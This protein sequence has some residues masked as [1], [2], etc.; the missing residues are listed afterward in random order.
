M[1]IME[2]TYRVAFVDA[3]NSVKGKMIRSINGDNL[4]REIEA[5]FNEMNRNGYE[6]YDQIEVNSS[7]STILEGYML[8]FKRKV[9]NSERDDR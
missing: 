7:P 8:I 2:K 3:S 6:Y 9:E 4:A 5:T 1:M